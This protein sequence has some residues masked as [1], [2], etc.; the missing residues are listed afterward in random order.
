MVMSMLITMC[1]SFVSSG[2]GSGR[3]VSRD[4]QRVE[5]NYSL[6][7]VSGK[8]FSGYFSKKFPRINLR[9]GD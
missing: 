6:P 2:A 1:T 7:S 5:E 9:G 3:T 8:L 4:V